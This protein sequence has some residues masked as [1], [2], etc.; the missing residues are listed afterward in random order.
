MDNELTKG[1]AYVRYVDEWIYRSD[2]ERLETGNTFSQEIG[3]AYEK[4]DFTITPITFQ[5]G[6]F[7]WKKLYLLG[8]VAYLINEIVVEKY[9]PYPF[10]EDIDN[11]WGLVGTLGYDFMITKQLY[12]FL[13]TR[14]LYSK[15]N[16]Y[17]NNNKV[18]RE[19]L[20]NLEGS[21]GV[22]FKF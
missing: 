18:Y 22:G 1:G 7:I 13:E 16:I 10:N 11:S 8:G 4:V 5:M 19:N 14:Y 9:P 2:I 17:V 12:L 15:A 3:I 20:S 6:K 21:I